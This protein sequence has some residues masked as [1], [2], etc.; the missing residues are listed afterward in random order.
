MLELGADHVWLDAT[1]L[2]DFAL[3]FP[4]I[5]AVLDEV[6]LD[7]ARD[8]LPVAPAAHY[9]C[10]GVVADLD[11]ATSLPG[12]WAAGE[13][14]CNGVMGANRLASN[15]LLEGLVM[16]ERAAVA[17]RGDVSAETSRAAELILMPP[18]AADPDGR[19]ELQATMSSSAGIG[20]DLPGLLAAESAVASLGDVPGR[21][22]RE[23][24]DRAS[25]EM[26]NLVV[27]AGARL[28]AAEV[29]TE[30]VGC[31]VRT[32]QPVPAVAR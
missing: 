28:A 11:G 6:G 10:G 3:R 22:W 30:S 13:V 31:H 16:G 4:T 12:L 2:D 23:K 21:V 7:P 15:S 29:R 18:P 5:A 17:V 19:L 14:A 20:R 27:A 24:V 25:V 1:G 32:D 26:A 9:C 8:W